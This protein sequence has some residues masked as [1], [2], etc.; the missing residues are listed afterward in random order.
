[1]LGTAKTDADSGLMT[2]CT[3]ERCTETRQ[4]AAQLLCVA[5]GSEAWSL[6]V[7]VLM[8]GL[9]PNPAVS[10][11]MM[12]ITANLHDVFYRSSTGLG[13]ATGTYIA[14]N[15]GGGQPKTAIVTVR[16]RAWTD[17]NVCGDHPSCRAARH[18]ISHRMAA[19]AQWSSID[20]PLAS[21]N[22]TMTAG[23]LG[24]D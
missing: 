11:S 24:S 4:Q 20:T 7:M 16:V 21:I 1:M 10:I 13:A 2:P 22:A 6:E 17:A 23:P 9:L 3:F 12:S 8:S 19:V 15:L 14:Q 18:S 5:A